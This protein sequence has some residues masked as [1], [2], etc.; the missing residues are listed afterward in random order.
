MIINLVSYKTEESKKEIINLLKEKYKDNY[1]LK[2]REI[3]DTLIL[4]DKKWIM[5]PEN[6]VKTLT[7]RKENINIY[8]MEVVK[9][10]LLKDKT[11]RHS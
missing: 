3:S 1:N 4:P 6:L 7:K 5:C 10:A 8:T 11:F 2:F 9:N